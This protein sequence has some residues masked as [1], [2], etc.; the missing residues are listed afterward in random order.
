MRC[1]EAQ[2]MLHDYAQGNLPELSE[3]RLQNH[4]ACCDSCHSQY[5]VLLDSDKFIQMH[6]EDYI[7][8]PPATSIVDAVMARILSEEKWA[9]PIGKKV[10]TLTVRMRRIGLSVAMVLLMICSFTLYHNSD[11]NL[12]S[13]MPYTA[14]AEALSSDNV[15]PE[16]STASETDQ[17]VAVQTIDSGGETAAPLLKHQKEMRVNVITSDMEPSSNKPN[18]SVILSF[19]GILITVLTMSWFTR[20]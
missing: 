9:I 2:E 20:A 19:F 11:D 14:K 13:F 17:D 12:N 5:D 3:R 4:L 7:A 16:V 1:D 10:F 15:K 8:N 6:K 18:Y